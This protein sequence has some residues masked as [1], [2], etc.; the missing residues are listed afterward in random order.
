MKKK[1]IVTETDLNR[2]RP[3]LDS[4]QK[5]PGCNLDS[6]NRL[7]EELNRARVVRDSE[8]PADVIAMNSTIE[9]EDLSDGEVMIF[10][11]VYPPHADISNGKVS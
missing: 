9:V 5:T 3:L 1:I 4:N 2:L 10:T 11:L 6:L 8:L 7:R